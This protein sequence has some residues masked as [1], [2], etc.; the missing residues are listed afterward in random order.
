M[1]PPTLATLIAVAVAVA[2]AAAAA[3]A[4]AAVATERVSL[5]ST[6]TEANGVS[7]EPA[8]SAD[9]RYVAF[10]SSASNFV[11]GD[12]NGQ[13]VFVRDRAAGTTARVAVDVLGAQAGRASAHP[14]ISA[15]GRFVAFESIAPNLVPGDT[16]AREDVFVKDRVTGAIERVSV[17]SQGSQGLAASGK[18]AI[19]GDGRFVAFESSASLVPDD[20]NRSGDT[21]SDGDVFVHDRVLHTTVRVSVDSAGHE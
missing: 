20:T 3:P 12:G 6:Q 10:V 8:L 19:S 1:Q 11:L 4:A 13:E 17:T 14:A 16:N 21:G 7:A 5:T 18:P 9:G 2:F 15:D